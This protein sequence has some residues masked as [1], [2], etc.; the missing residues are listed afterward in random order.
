[1]ARCAW[2]R[3]VTQSTRKVNNFHACFHLT[4]DIMRVVR[5]RDKIMAPYNK[6]RARANSKKSPQP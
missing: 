4:T 5:T 6:A 3:L 1:M 2:P